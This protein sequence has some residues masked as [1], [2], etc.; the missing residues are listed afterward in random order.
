MSKLL[1]ALAIGLILWGFYGAYHAWELHLESQESQRKE[2][3]S[4]IIVPQRLPGLPWE[5][6]SSLAD[7][8]RQGAL[9][10]GN[11]LAVCGTRLQDPRKGWIEL[12][13]CVMIASKSPQ[14]ARHVFAE[15]SRRTP[16]SSPIWSRVQ[17]LR[18]SYE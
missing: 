10:L 12:D 14:A 7:A 9:A 16:P 13:Y 4:K 11:W 3:A 8:Q 18:K 6:E 2:A 17:E 1:W 5:L 15:V